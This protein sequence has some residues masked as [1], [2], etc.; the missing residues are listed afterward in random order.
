MIIKAI[1]QLFET[2]TSLLQKKAGTYTDEVVCS[3]DDDVVDCEK[4]KESY[5]GVPAPT[6]LQ[7][8]EWFGA[9][10]IT[11][12]GMDVVQQEAQIKQQQEEQ[13]EELIASG[14]LIEDEDIHQR[15]YELATKNWNTVAE[16][17][18]GSEN[19]H[20]GPGGWNSGNGM[21]QFQ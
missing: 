6:Y 19:F 12:K 8:D 4:F 10:V 16:T 20:E 21:G 14:I 3:V 13:K 2:Q 11:E 7:S 9:P 1:K 5:V 15:M 17:Q 18:G